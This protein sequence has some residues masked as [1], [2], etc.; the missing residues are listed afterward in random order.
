MSEQM[1]RILAYALLP[2]FSVLML[3]YTFHNVKPEAVGELIFR[4][5]LFSGGLAATIG[6]LAGFL[7]GKR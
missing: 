2:I 4:A 5:M 7:A 6:F 3:A 1:K